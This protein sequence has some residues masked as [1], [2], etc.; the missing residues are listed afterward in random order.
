MEG[1][2]IIAM[3]KVDLMKN[4]ST[5]F[6]ALLQ[7]G[8][9][10]EGYNREAYNSVPIMGLFKEPIK[11]YFPIWNYCMIRAITVDVNGILIPN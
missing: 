6:S 11:I 9:L 5:E 3:P 7:C 4:I 1:T 2:G 8:I 10:S